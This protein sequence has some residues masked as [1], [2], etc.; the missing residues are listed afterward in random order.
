[1]C[2]ARVNFRYARPLRGGPE[3]G[4]KRCVVTSNASQL[5]PLNADEVVSEGKVF[6]AVLSTLAMNIIAAMST[7]QKLD[8]MLTGN[9]FMNVALGGCKI[10]NFQ[11]LPKR[12]CSC[13]SKPKV[14]PREDTL[15]N[16]RD[17]LTDAITADVQIDLFFYEEHKNNDNCHAMRGLVQYANDKVIKASR[18]SAVS[19]VAC[20]ITVAL[21]LNRITETESPLSPTS[22]KQWRNLRKDLLQVLQKCT[23]IS[24]NLWEGQQSRAKLVTAIG[25]QHFPPN[26][27]HRL[28]ENSFAAFEFL[29]PN[30]GKVLLK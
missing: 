28:N 11:H 4:S 13:F 6:G 22:M 1:V 12:C 20:A 18:T 23:K 25:N 24:A 3:A 15:F 16:V 21:V 26:R 30:K 27:P 19:E 17:C 29:M 10:Q 8:Y 9:R 14:A 7:A 2:N 5:A